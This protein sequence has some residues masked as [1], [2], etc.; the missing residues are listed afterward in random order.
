MVPFGTTLVG[1][2]FTGAT[3]KPVPLQ[4]VEVCVGINGFG[5]T[6]T[7]KLNVLVQILG[8]VPEEAE[9]I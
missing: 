2:L 3:V 5:L 1:K 7:I 9:T 8:V 6:V 4:V